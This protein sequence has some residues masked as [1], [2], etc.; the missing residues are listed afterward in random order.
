MSDSIVDVDESN[1]A[2]V[3]EQ[4]T[5]PVVIDFWAPWCGPCVALTPTIEAVANLYLGKIKVVKINVDENKAISAKFGVRGIPYL[6][7]VEQGKPPR[8]IKQHT[9]TRLAMEFDAIV[10]GAA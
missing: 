5:I 7:V 9:R 10:Q 1:Y 4:S 6:A 8:Q 2:A 3:V